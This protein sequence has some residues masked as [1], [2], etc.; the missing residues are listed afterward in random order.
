MTDENKNTDL[1]LDAA[2]REARMKYYRQILRKQDQ[3]VLKRLQKIPDDWASV[4]PE[5]PI[6]SISDDQKLRLTDLKRLKSWEL[7]FESLYFHYLI[8]AE[9]AVISLMQQHEL[10]EAEIGEAIESIEALSLEIG[11]TIT[12]FRHLMMSLAKRQVSDFYYFMISYFKFNK[13]PSEG[14]DRDFMR[15]RDMLLSYIKNH[16]VIPAI[17]SDIVYLKSEI[18]KF[19]EKSSS[20]TGW[21]MKENA[22]RELLESE[23]PKSKK[24]PAAKKTDQSSDAENPDILTLT[25]LIRLVSQSF[26]YTKRLK[27]DFLFLV[28]YYNEN[29]GKLFRINYVIDSFRQKLTEGVIAKPVFD[30]FLE[31]KETFNKVKNNLEW[32]G[33]R[34]FGVKDLG[35]GEIIEIIYRSA[36]IIEQC[37][38]RSASYDELRNF[39]EDLLY[40]LENEYF[41]IYPERRRR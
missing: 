37:Y 4:D 26:S 33:L 10:S 25:K 9:E 28:Y 12:D 19:Y 41:Y 18:N 29:D 22:I 35:Y 13:L 2:Y 15:L 36:K 40:K 14:F 23:A 39:R 30:S 16:R 3:E 11:N 34:F 6:A 7:K 24:G 38:L 21:K 20:T 8:T 1:S 27:K 31:I 17:I 32:K 5:L